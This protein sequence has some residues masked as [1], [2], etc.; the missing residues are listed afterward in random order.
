[1]ALARLSICTLLVVAASLVGCRSGVERDVVQRELRQQ[2]DQIYALEDYLQEYQQ[3][4]CDVRAENA[5]LK[6]QVVQRQF[7]DRA[8]TGSEREVDTLPSPPVQAPSPIQLEPPPAEVAPTP[9]VPSLDLSNP[10]VP[11][12]GSSSAR[13][14][15]R[16]S[17]RAWEQ[18]AAKIEA[19]GIEVV[20]APPTAVVLRGE[21]QVEVNN[22]NTEAGPRVLLTVEPIDD[23][24]RRVTFLGKLSVLVLDPAAPEKQRQLAR[25]DFSS[26]ELVDV[27]NDAAD[28]GYELPL[29]LPTGSPTTRPLELWV[30][31][32][33]E[34]GEKLLGRTTMDLGRAGRFATAEIQPAEKSSNQ[35]PRH[36]AQAAVAEVPSSNRQRPRLTILD[37]NVQQSG[38]QIAKPGEFV[39]QPS[40]ASTATSE[41]KLATRLIPESET[42]PL[43]SSIPGNANS[44]PASR[45]DRYRVADAPAWTP[46]RPNGET[47]KQPPPDHIVPPPGPGWAAERFTR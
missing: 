36:P 7:R 12:L 39:G 42:V 18:A 32:L 46:N 45:S 13:E 26:D 25:W 9:E 24:G 4:L 20:E 44:K 27:A 40:S 11:P 6:R 37:S 2:E 33:P 23:E 16:I 3:L 34:D 10:D 35:S 28:G 17:D 41:W 47:S 5:A 43:A 19:D 14:P 22:D 29:Q 38:W 15:S 1:M 8:P 31:L 30:R 21:V